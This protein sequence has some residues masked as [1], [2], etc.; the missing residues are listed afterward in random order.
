VAAGFPETASAHRS[1]LARSCP[2]A[3]AVR[4][5]LGPHW[6]SVA[7]LFC[8]VASVRHSGGCR[9]RGAPGLYSA[10]CPCLFGGGAPRAF[11]KLLCAAAT[12]LAGHYSGNGGQRS[13]AWHREP[14]VQGLLCGGRGRTAS[15]PGD[16]VL[17]SRPPAAAG[18]SPRSERTGRPVIAV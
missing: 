17:V 8:S 5:P 10:S 18:P 4:P 11:T 15:Q 2:S 7:R 16:R 1:R 12:G 9:G 14:P 3:R 6:D 13:P